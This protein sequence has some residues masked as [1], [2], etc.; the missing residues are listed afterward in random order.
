[1]PESIVQEGEST[2][3]IG[4]GR[5]GKSG[6]TFDIREEEEKSNREIILAPRKTIK[7]KM[8]GLEEIDWPIM[9]ADELA[10]AWNTKELSKPLLVLIME[11][12]KNQP[13]IWSILRDPRFEGFAIQAEELSVLTSRKEDHDAFDTFIRV[14]G[15]SNQYFYANTHRLRADIDPAWL[16]NFQRIFFIGQL[17]DDQEI[18]T[19]YSASNVSSEM[20]LEDFTNRLRTQPKKY[21]W[22]DKFPNKNA[23]FQIYI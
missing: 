16:A 8:E 18:Q 7:A 12:Q 15:Q 20:T 11:H 13:S 6:F 17:A 21:N 22:W 5:A 14:V 19:L 9:N 1:M 2:L 10:D 3:I 4:R 23:A